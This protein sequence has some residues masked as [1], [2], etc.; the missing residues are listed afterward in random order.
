[1]TQVPPEHRHPHG[2]QTTQWSLVASAQGS[3]SP[4]AEASLAALCQLYWQPLFTWLRHRGHREHD[5][6]DLVQEF[7]ARLIAGH[8]LN[9]AQPEKGRFRTFLLVVLK[10]FVA[11]QHDRQLTLRRGGGVSTVPLSPGWHGEGGPATP[12]VDPDSAY[13]R[14]WALTILAQTLATLSHEQD[15]AGRATEF[16]LLK[17]FLTAPRGEVPYQEIAPQLGMTAASARSALHRLRRRFQFVFR[18]TVAATL[19]HPE[20]TDDEIRAI[21]A[22]LA[23]A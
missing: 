5:A 10:R 20:E 8:W 13:D 4:A 17:P 12:A 11:N 7:F 14:A 1:M 2:F 16:R 21:I 6:E 3:P 15:A 19:H 23:A 18:S 9:A 22:A